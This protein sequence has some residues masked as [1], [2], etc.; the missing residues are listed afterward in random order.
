MRMRGIRRLPVV[1][2][3]GELIGIVA[4]DDLLALLAEE[5]GELAKIITREQATEAKARR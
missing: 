1:G 3:Q 4:V 2:K 5:M